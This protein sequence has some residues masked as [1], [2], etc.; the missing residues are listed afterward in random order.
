MEDTSRSLPGE[1]AKFTFGLPRNSAYYTHPDE[2]PRAGVR[3]PTTVKRKERQTTMQHMQLENRQRLGFLASLGWTM[4]RIS[5][6]LGWSA[7]TIANELLN[8]RVDSDKRHGCSNRLC[9]HYEGCRLESYTATGKGLRKNQPKCF[10]ACPDFREEVCHRLARP[11]FVCNGCEK[12]HNCPL[13]KK[14]YIPESA[15]ANYEGT[16]HSSRTGIHPD[17]E[18][19]REMDK[20]ISPGLKRGQSVSAIIRANADIFKGYRRSTVYGWIGDGLFTAKGSDLPFAGTRRKPRK[21]PET[22]TTAKCRVGRT[23]REMREW[24]RQHEGVVPCELDT[25]IGSI[26]GKVLFTMVFPDTGLAL[27]FL[28]DERTA[29]TCTRIFNML[30]RVAGA[31]LFVRLFRAILTDNGPEFSEPEMIEKYRPDPERNPTKLLPRGIRV[32]FCDPYCSSQKPHIE[33]FHNELRRI[34]QKGTSFDPLAQGQIN[35]ALSHLNSYPRESLG[36][37]TPYDVFV[38][39][40][41]AEGKAFLDALGIVR[42]Q[43]NQVTLH[44]FL[45][46]Q[47]YQRAADKAIL[48]KNGITSQKPEAS[49]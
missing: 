26:S 19:V 47:K 38:E 23:I 34:L 21:K 31:A 9:A 18:Q 10:E 36:G 49:K 37:R 25:V 44:P 24:L 33:R 4:R 2:R 20:V 13:R 11:P 29:Q 40:H 28:R 46:G 1:G 14:Y 8:R 30:W 45:L 16:L 35:L 5:E 6:D 41:G 12:E 48:K 27:A 22:K 43:S 3:S 32:W 17:E 15:Q 39:K 42:V 7:Q